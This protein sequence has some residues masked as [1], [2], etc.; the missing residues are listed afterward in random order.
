MQHADVGNSFQP[1]KYPSGASRCVRTII[2]AFK[3]ETLW[4]KRGFIVIIF[5]LLSKGLMFRKLTHLNEH[6]E[7]TSKLK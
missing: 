1:N 2:T 3:I 5:N 6:A 4:C 7:Q